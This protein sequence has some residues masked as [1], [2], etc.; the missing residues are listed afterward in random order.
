[1]QVRITKSMHVSQNKILPASQIDEAWFG[2]HVV[3]GYL[4]F[5]HKDGKNI[6]HALQSY[7]AVVVPDMV[8]VVEGQFA[9]RVGQLTQYK[10]DA[11]CEIYDRPHEL[12]LIDSGDK[13]AWVPVKYCRIYVAPLTWVDRIKRLCGLE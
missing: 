9:G 1:M 10:Y 8:Q 13:A 2:S 6:A 11:A 5:E 12:Y 4:A 3:K 7:E